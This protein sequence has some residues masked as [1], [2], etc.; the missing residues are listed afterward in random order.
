MEPAIPHEWL[1]ML[2]FQGFKCRLTRG[3]T[4]FS[5][6]NL[7][8]DSQD[9]VLHLG[10]LAIFM[11]RSLE[12]ANLARSARPLCA[13]AHCCLK[14]LADQWSPDALRPLCFE[15]RWK[16]HEMKDVEN[17]GADNLRRINLRSL[18]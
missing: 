3:L 14:P 10:R 8:T 2:K 9:D 13:K 16:F 7:P 1:S 18:M 4:T 12:V 17:I 15:F 5:V 11:C 6:K